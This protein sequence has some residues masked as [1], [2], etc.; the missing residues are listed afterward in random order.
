M[1][2]NI[3]F[4]LRSNLDFFS[5]KS[6]QPLLI[7]NVKNAIL[8]YENLIFEAG[9]YMQFSGDDAISDFNLSPDA[10]NETIVDVPDS[11][12][13]SYT[14]NIKPENSDSG[15]TAF[16]MG[17]HHK[18]FRINFYPLLNELGLLEEKFIDNKYFYVNDYAKKEI[19]KLCAQSKI[20]LDNIEGNRF[21]K[22]KVIYNLYLSFLFRDKIDSNIFIDSIHDELIKSLNN[23]FIVNIKNSGC[24]DFA[25]KIETYETINGLLSFK[26][27]NFSKL[28]MDEILDLRKDKAFIS[29]RK[30]IEKLSDLSYDEDNKDTIEGK[31]IR[32]FISEF[33][34]FSP[35]S[36]D[37]SMSGCLN[38]C[39]LIP[40]V[41]IASSAISTS[42]D[43]LEKYNFD[44]S[45]ISYIMK[46]N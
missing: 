36:K 22:E 38:I 18:S 31:F 21:F 33:K 9:G 20:Y 5:E 19:K 17:E 24:S 16:P 14:L 4:P 12:M 3:F 23:D 26:L 37:I 34:E 2:N 30:E 29:F 39:S 45:W 35:S 41:G 43:L 11:P 6:K 7:K 8:F 32:D 15:A 44:K 13:G 10:A 42:K 27:P 46:Y 1:P 28:G 40:Y 25:N